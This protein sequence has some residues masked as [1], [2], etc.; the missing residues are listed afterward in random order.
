MFKYRNLAAA[1]LGFSMLFSAGVQAAGNQEVNVIVDGNKLSKPGVMLNGATMV[2]MRAIFEALG[3]EVKWDGATRSVKANKKSTE[4]RLTLGDPTAYINGEVKTLS[5]PA[6]SID[7]ATM[8]PLRFIGE[9]LGAEVKWD[10]ATRT[11]NVNGKDSAASA[12][13]DASADIELTVV[14]NL[15]KT[16]QTLE[17]KA[18]GEKDCKASFD[19]V[20]LQ[21]DIPMV[22]SK[23]SPGTYS[24]TFTA[25][26]DMSVTGALLVVRLKAKDGSK[27][28]VADYSKTVS[29]NASEAPT[30]SNKEASAYF[31]TLIP[32][33]GKV[34]K[35]NPVKLIKAVFN[36][37]VKKGVVR[38]FLDGDDVSSSCTFAY[39]TITYK[40]KK[41]LAAGTHKVQIVGVDNDGEK[42]DYSWKFTCKEGAAETTADNS[43]KLTLPAENENIGDI[44]HLVGTTGSNYKVDYEIQPQ[45][46]LA[47]VITIKGSHIDGSVKADSKGNFKKDVDLSSIK[48]DSVIN[49]TLNVYDAKGK[50]VETFTRKVNKKGS[51]VSGKTAETAK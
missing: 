17:V 5:V 39:K 2:P 29:V 19:I 15:I 32:A 20:G 11:A 38:M 9:A 36:H 48:S 49:I 45:S 33:P 42:I 7:G 12:K 28:S 18:E 22:E 40:A 44:L 47:G 26:K 4:I 23:T 51:A 25:T 1:V 6:A 27:E 43:L 30:L 41:E 8:V 34:I 46:S 21:K 37:E 31:K 35:D 14:N 10:G 3:A 24:G 50:K 16:G 13:A